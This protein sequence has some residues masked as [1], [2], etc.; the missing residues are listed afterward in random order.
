MQSTETADDIRIRRQALLSTLRANAGVNADQEAR[1]QGE[2]RRLGMTPDGVRQAQRAGTPLP[3]RLRNLDITELPERAP[4]TSN[5]LSQPNNAR[6][7]HDD[8]DNMVDAEDVVRAQGSFAGQQLVAPP[9]RAPTFG[10]LLRGI[11]NAFMDAV[12][13]EGTVVA[14]TKNL[15]GDQVL[16]ATGLDRARDATGNLIFTQADR[17]AG[18][19]RFLEA[20]SNFERNRPDVGDGFGGA[21]YSG[22][23]SFARMAPALAASVALRN[24]TPSLVAA[25]TQTGG[26]A[27]GRYDARGATQNEALLGAGGEAAVEV[28]TEVIPI[29]KLL[30]MVGAKSFKTAVVDWAKSQFADQV[31]EQIATAAQDAIDTA[32]ANPDKTWAEYW[33]ERPDAAFQTAVATVVQGALSAGSIGGVNLVT[34]VAHQRRQQ[35]EQQQIAEQQAAFADNLNKVAEASKLRARSPASFEAFMEEATAD[36]PVENVYIDA[37]VFNQSAQEAG[38]DLNELA[39]SMPELARQLEAASTTEGDLQIP[40]AS[41][42]AHVAGTDLGKALIDHIR[43]DPSAPSRAEVQTAGENAREQIRSEV[44]R[45]LATAARDDSAAAS[46]ENVKQGLLAELNRAGRFTPQVNDAYASWVSAFYA[47]RAEALGITPEEMAERYPLRVMSV[48]PA[49]AGATLEQETQ[50]EE[51][52]GFIGRVVDMLKG[53]PAQL[54]PEAQTE[55]AASDTVQLIH[56]GRQTGLTETDPALWGSSRATPADE[57]ARAA[58]GSAP[59]RTYFYDAAN[60]T[61]EPAVTGASPFA[62]ETTIPAAALYDFDADPQNLREGRSPSEYETAIREAGFKGYRSNE[63]VNGAV[64]VFEPLAL[65]QFGP[66]REW[67]QFHALKARMNKLQ[68]EERRARSEAFYAANPGS[69]EIVSSRPAEEFRDQAMRELFGTGAALEEQLARYAMVEGAP[70][71]VRVNGERL[72]LRPTPAARDAAF[73][74]MASQG[75]QYEPPRQYAKVDVARA[76]RMADMFD[77]MQHAPDDPLVR[78]SYRAMIEETLLQY[79]FIKA[80]GLE[81]SLMVEGMEDPYAASPRLAT[82]DVRNNN[83]LWVYPTDFGFGGP[84]ASDIDISGNPLL[85]WTDEYIGDKRLRANDVFRIVHDY[86]GHV[87][88][89]FGFRADGEENAWQSHA[90]MFTPLARRAMTTETR[91]Q[92]SWVNFGPYGEKNRTASASETEYAPQKIG[93]LPEWVSE[94]GFLGG[95][96]SGV[97]VGETREPSVFNQETPVDTRGDAFKAWFGDSKAADASG[98]PLVVYHGTGADF[99]AFSLDKAGSNTGAASAQG[100]FFFSESAETANDYAYLARSNQEVKAWDRVRALELKGKYSEAEALTASLENETFENPATPNVMPVYLSLQNPLVFDFEGESYS[101]GTSETKLSELVQQARD[102]GR[103]GLILRNLDDAV[104]VNDPTTHFVV[105]APTQIKSIFNRGSFDPNDPVIYNQSDAPTNPP[106]FSAL[107]RAVEESKTAKAPAAQWKAT[108]AK[109]PGVKAEELEW[110]GLNEWLDMQQGSVERAAIVDYL[111]A[112]GI[113]LEEVVLGGANPEL[114]RQLTEQ[115]EQE[116]YA[117][118]IEM[119]EDNGASEY[120]VEEGENENGDTVWQVL[121]SDEEFDPESGDSYDSE[122]GAHEDLNARQREEAEDYASSYVSSESYAIEQRVEDAMRDQGG[123]QYSDYKLPGADETYR[124]FLLKLPVIRG[125]RFKSSEGHFDGQGD[126]IAHARFTTRRDAEGRRILF[127]EEVQS[128]HHETGREQGY[129]Q[130]IPQEE[131]DRLRE[132]SEDAYVAVERWYVN[133]RSAIEAET[134]SAIARLAELAETTEDTR[135]AHSLRGEVDYLNT[136]LERLREASAPGQV[137]REVFSLTERA[138][139]RTLNDR[140]RESLMLLV[141]EQQ[142]V[143]LAK[144][145]A[146]IAYQSALEGVEPAPWTKSWSQLVMKRMIRYAVDNGLDGVAWINGNQQNGGQTGGDGAWFYERNLVNETN[147]ILKK[148]GSRV[149]KIEFRHPDV[150]AETEAERERLVAR[151]EEGIQEDIANGYSEDEARA[152][153]EEYFADSFADLDEAARPADNLGLQNGFYLTD[154]IKEQAAQGFTLFQPKR[155]QIAFGQDLSLTPSVITLLR[156]ADLSTFLHETGHFFLEVDAHIA[157]QPDAPQQIKDDFQALLDWFGV[158]DIATWNAMT[159]DQ[160]RDHHE[161]F[162]RG[163]EMYLLE[164]R[165]PTLGLSGLFRRFSA[166]MKAVYKNLTELKVTLT[167]EVRGVMDRMVASQEAIAEAEAA[168]NLRPFANERPTFMSEEQWVEYQ[169]QFAPATAEGVEEVQSRAV[170]DMKWLSN[171]KSKALKRLQREANAQRRLVKAE[172]TEEVRNEPVY[173]A[174]RFL[175]HGVDAEGNPIENAG[176]LDLDTLVAEYGDAVDGQPAPA[177][178]K[179]RRG[180]RYGLVGVG[181]IHP[182]LVAADFGFASGDAMIRAM[183]EAEDINQRIAGLTDSRMLERFGDL[184]DPRAIE[185]AA[186]LAVSNDARIRVLNTEY[187]ALAKA[188]GQPRALAAAAREHAARVVNGMPLKTLKPYHFFNAAARAGRNAEKAIRAGDLAQAAT[189]KRN[190][191]MNLQA[192][193]EVI[194]AKDEVNKAAKLFT[195][196]ITAKDETIAKTRE[197][198]LVNAARGILGRYGISRSKNDPMAELEKVKRYDPELFADMTVFLGLMPSRDTDYMTITYEDFVAMRDNVAMLWQLSRRSKQVVIDGQLMELSQVSDALRNTL[199]ERGIPE[200]RPGQSRAPTDMERAARRISG[201][202]AALRRVESWVRAIDNG[203]RGAFRRYIWQ[204]VSEAADTYRAESARY[205]LRFADIVKPIEADLAKKTKIAAPELG[206]TFNTKAELLHAILH[207]GNGSNLSKLLLG[208]G[209]ASKLADGSLDTTKW[210]AFISRMHAEGTLTKEHYDFA[211]AIWNL[212]ESTKPAAQRAH[213]Q[214]YGR[215]FAEVTADP[216]MTPW[217]EYAGGYVPA[218]T[219]S[220]L[221]ADAAIRGEELAF[222]ESSSSM[223]PAAS[224]GFT[225]SRTEDYTR[226]LALDVRLLPMHIDKVLRFSHLGPAVKDVNR[227][228]RQRGFNEA[229]EAFDPTAQKDLL[230]PWL[231]RAANQTVSTPIAGEAGKGIDKFFRELR[232][233]TGL[234]LMFANVSNVLQQTTGILSAATRVKKANLAQ[235]MWQ[236]TRSPTKTTEAV[237]QLSEFMANRTSSQMFE[238]RQALEEML[239]NPNKYE[240]LRKFSERHGYFAQMFYQNIMD[241]VVWTASYNQQ[242][243]NGRDEAEAIRIANSVI[244]ETQNSMSPEDISRFETGTSFTRAFTQFYSHFNNQ[245][246]LLG[247]E[248]IITQQSDLG[249]GKKVG[250]YSYLI[251]VGYMAQAAVADAIAQLFRGGWEDEEDDGYLDDVLA[252]FFSSQLKYGAAM[253]PIAGQAFNAALAMAN[254]NPTDDRIS[255]SPFVSIVEGGIRAPVEIGKSIFQGDEFTRRDIRD[256]ATL[257]GMLTNLPLGWLGRP[258]GYLKDVADGK[259]EPTGPVDLAR[260]LLTGTPSPESKK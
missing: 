137:L 218:T 6:V 199:V 87:K 136:R 115:I 58:E 36:G 196:I 73:A 251:V 123:A 72:Q 163:M 45:M 192:A 164:G 37:A 139:T 142:R 154:K 104:M 81:I 94:A 128:T 175:S 140:S 145:E 226:Q 80:T 186:N 250:R 103:D 237:A 62:Y 165:A 245:A 255:V 1:D 222:Q 177:W 208:R 166:W 20:Q 68:Q 189:H 108:L 110:T 190:Q 144:R 44:E 229:L 54:T 29:S 179:L 171:A 93:L 60:F 259:V 13:P 26:E 217:G 21:V 38:I 82:E 206:Y 95:P 77:Q 17:D 202:R 12:G 48:A 32:I 14:G 15:L 131:I 197:M 121:H 42:A 109:T 215:Y 22:V 246:N 160:K 25:G 129:K 10:N 116:V 203:E 88:D 257:L 16:R 105:F 146:E 134:E 187:A 30:D 235:A 66:V 219:D 168:F 184:A 49:S 167:D 52:R 174:M 8:I 74:Y 214:M 84:N 122:E 172:V 24:P 99:D 173:R 248:A 98:K 67:Q 158:R 5:W 159:V 244:R 228:L 53:A 83:H 194:K 70:K 156:T 92:N 7:G 113:Q 133:N 242:I 101:S 241:V 127:L 43:V 120:R 111:D 39:Q 153:S 33:E 40:V 75:L 138:V 207:T 125:E 213:H 19:T 132:A 230:L 204:P 234:Q 89:G 157:S 78:A 28:L 209:W 9:R 65:N 50:T 34:N 232:S 198:A 23:E 210:D 181:G 71:S 119:F 227:I 150:I 151:M 260:G 47:T 51:R 106:F 191:I 3:P 249:L 176:K 35:T 162:A 233:R 178:T 185:D 188:T 118:A 224:N 254:D 31:G 63:V 55:T 238:T 243:E 148:L 114:E 76:K 195:R 193:R 231:Q 107:K 2:A 126:V 216:F 4:R 57:R 200:N 223:F 220:F 61:P 155:G 170:R 41:F 27:Y 169:S 100:T 239:L 64:A 253:V 85:E 112:G 130:D 46:A 11:G 258:A 56:F 221:V 212:L 117:D 143:A 152:S 90:A 135:F 79:Q 236:Y 252:W 59:G 147:T 182:D 124:E 205:L 96:N 211:Q 201:F 161:R 86:F 225:K 18:E 91:G 180:G 240:R 102:E 183:V 97:P 141:E 69:E 149:E 256:T 247:T